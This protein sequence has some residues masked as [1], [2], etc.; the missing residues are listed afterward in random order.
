MTAR[1]SARDL[2]PT[3]EAAIAAVR[4]RAVRERCL[5]RARI[6]QLLEAEGIRIDV[7]ALCQSAPAQA[8]VIL[9]FHP[10]R[11]IADGRSVAE[12][13]RD[14]GAYRSQFETGISNGG[15][16]AHPGGNRDEWERRLFDGAYHAAVVDEPTAVRPKYGALN[17]AGFS[18]GPAPA[19]GSCALVLSAHETART[20]FLFGDSSERHEAMGTADAFESVLA[21]LLE[22]LAATGQMLGLP[23]I[24][25]GECVA[26]LSGA[27][28]R[29]SAFSR[30]VD[31]Y[32][33]THTHGP[34]SLT[35][36]ADALLL[37]PSFHS[38]PTAV[39][40]LQAAERY[41]LAVRWHKGSQLTK[42]TFPT[43]TPVDPGQQPTRWQQFLLSG[44]AAYLTDRII[45]EYAPDSRRLTAA[46]IG[47]AA[48]AFGRQPARWSEWGAPD[49]SLT[50][51]KDLWRI[52]VVHGVPYAG[53]SG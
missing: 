37:D 41:R 11:L 17:L 40:L 31:E 12:A 38:T 36:D 39:A 46:A 13:L 35:S 34:I 6:E 30:V 33:E 5:H 2:S 3:G 51:F 25:L 23:G 42:A 14:E 10:D 53:T 27:V 48:R 21:A 44:R 7:G 22:R 43:T 52:L 4:A 26:R 32:I 1:Q 47:A 45:C 18:N 16:T 49:P 24:R 15:L 9:N 8:R 19:F 28:R 20:T 29:P 50:V